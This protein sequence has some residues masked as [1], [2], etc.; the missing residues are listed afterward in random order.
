MIDFEQM[1]LGQTLPLSTK[2]DWEDSENRGTFMAAQ[3][4]TEQTGGN[5]LFSIDSIFKDTPAG[6]KIAGFNITRIK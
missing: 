4:Y 3:A 5:V 6:R 1:E 2:V